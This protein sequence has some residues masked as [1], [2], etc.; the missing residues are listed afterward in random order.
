MEW[1][2]VILLSHGATLKLSKDS[3]PKGAQLSGN[4][5]PYILEGEES[6]HCDTGHSLL[7]TK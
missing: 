4:S 1:F 7:G 3:L 2:E 6:T 5:K